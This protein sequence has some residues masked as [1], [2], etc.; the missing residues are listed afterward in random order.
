VTEHS[1]NLGDHIH[2]NDTIIL[3]KKPTCVECIIREAIEIELQP[4]RMNRE[5]DFSLSK[6]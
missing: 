3:A 2:F 5:G 4:D 1:I 6:S